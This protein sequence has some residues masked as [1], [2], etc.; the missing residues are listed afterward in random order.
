MTEQAAAIK[1]LCKAQQ[2]MGRVLK[3]APNPHLKRKYADLGS[4][5]DAVFP[6]MHDNGFAVLQPA[7]QDE[8]GPF[9]E[10]IFAHEGGH[11]FSSRVYLVI[12]KH[13]MQGVG[14]AHTYARR[15]GLMAMAGVAPEDDDGEGTKRAPQQAAPVEPPFNADGFTE[16]L[17]RSMGGAQYLPDLIALWKEANRAKGLLEVAQYK[18]I[19]AAKDKRKAEITEHDKASQGPADNGEPY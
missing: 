2:E 4:V 10:T 3:N 13:D 19:E 15:Y 18:S 16:R 17:L 14:S 12:G 1:A 9:V 8:R 11:M 5:I 6:A 7:G